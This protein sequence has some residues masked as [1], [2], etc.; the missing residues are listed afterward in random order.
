MCRDG[1]DEQILPKGV[2][3]VV[4]VLGEHLHENA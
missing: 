3:V 4:C 2:P 1:L